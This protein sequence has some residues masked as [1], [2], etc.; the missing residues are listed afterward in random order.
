M[1][2]TPPKGK[3]PGSMLFRPS[4]A[5]DVGTSGSV[6]SSQASSHVGRVSLSPIFRSPGTPVGSALM[7]HAPLPSASERIGHHDGIKGK[8]CSRPIHFGLLLRGW[9][10]YR[11]R[12]ASF[13]LA[14][15]KPLDLPN[16]A[17]LALFGWTRCLLARPNW[18][19]LLRGPH[20][21]LTS[22]FKPVNELVPGLTSCLIPPA[23]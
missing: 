20:P 3:R 4:R 9:R 15:G 23:E 16:P 18:I 8:L 12:E 22:P 11:G 7:R 17:I 13:P 5:R 14:G 1:G 10:R 2:K 21:R 19:S 6:F